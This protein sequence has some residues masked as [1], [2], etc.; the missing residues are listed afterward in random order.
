MRKSKSR[1]DEVTTL[2]MSLTGVLGEFDAFIKAVAAEKNYF[3]TF[4]KQISSFFQATTSVEALAFKSHPMYQQLPGQGIEALTSSIHGL[5]EV[6][7]AAASKM[8]DMLSNAQTKRT[9][10]EKWKNDTI[11][12]LRTDIASYKDGADSLYKEFPGGNIHSTLERGG[13]IHDL[14]RHLTESLA[15]AEEK[16]LLE[17]ENVRSTL[18]NYWQTEEKCSVSFC[19]DFLKK[20]PLAQH[21]EPAPCRKKRELT[22]IIEATRKIL[23]DLRSS[24]GELRTLPEEMIP[25]ASAKYPTPFFARVWRTREAENDQELSVSRKEVVQVMKVTNGKYWAITDFQREGYVPSTILE[26]VMVSK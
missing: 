18:D 8:G 25:T 3:N 13:K 22:S 26:P 14:L 21:L 17:L 20:L 19:I 6:A 9:S 1:S 2:E 7:A 23:F 5:E 24:S 15:S 11:T 10:F 12:K 4:S 16:I